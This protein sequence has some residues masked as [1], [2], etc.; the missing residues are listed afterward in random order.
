MPPQPPTT[1]STST[2]HT[3]RARL[4]HWGRWCSAWG[5]LAKDVRKE[6]FKEIGDDDQHPLFYASR[7]KISSDTCYKVPDRSAGELH[8]VLMS[9]PPEASIKCGDNK[10]G[11]LFTGAQTVVSP[12]CKRP[13]ATPFAHRPDT[14]LRKPGRRNE[15]SHDKGRQQQISEGQKYWQT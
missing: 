14:D 11:K 4:D 5:Y 1:L 8:R 12:V 15:G 9:Y 6:L 10:C 7:A 13:T 3:P 2:L